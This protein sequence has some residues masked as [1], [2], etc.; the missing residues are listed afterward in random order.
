MVTKIL[1]YWIV[2]YTAIILLSMSQLKGISKHLKN[3]TQNICVKNS[4]GKVKSLKMKY[5]ENYLIDVWTLLLT[6]S[7]ELKLEWYTVQIQ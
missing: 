3:F 5:C 7:S 4:V 6:Y 2:C 1:C